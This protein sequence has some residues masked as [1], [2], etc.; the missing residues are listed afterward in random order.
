MENIDGLNRSLPLLFVPEHQV[1]PMADVLRHMVRF[2]SLAVD[3]D[4]KTR[5][6]PGPRRKVDVI[7]P[8]TIL[9]HTKIKT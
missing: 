3:E 9:T 7:N 1:N 4:E 5:I 8:F 2:E 6:V